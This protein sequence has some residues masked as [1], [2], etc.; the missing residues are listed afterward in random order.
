MDAWGNLVD[1]LSEDQFDDC[2]KKLLDM[3]SSWIM[4]HFVEHY[5]GKNPSRCRC[6][7]RTTHGLSYA[8]ELSRY[9]VG[10]IP[11]ETIH[12]FWQRLSFSNQGLFEPEV[13]ITEE[14]K[15]ISKWFQELD[16]C[17]KVTLKSKL[18][19][20]AY[21]DLKFMCHPLEKVNTKGAQKKPMTKHQRSTRHNPSYWEYVDALHSMQ[22]SISSVKHSASSSGQAIPRRIMLMLDQFHPCIHDSIEN[23]VDVK[24]DTNYGYRA[25]VALLELVKWSDEYINLLGGIDRYEE[26]KQFLLVDGLSMWMNITD[27]G[28][29]IA[30]RYNVILASLSLQQRM[31]SFPLRSQPPI[32]SFVHRVICI[33]HVYDNYFVQ[34]FLRDCCPLPPLALLWSL[35]SSCKAVTNSIY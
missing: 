9:V 10:T 24:A 35:S 7:M 32:D 27:M 8:Y 31:T 11:L 16:V 14:M 33:G 20:I 19:K 3:V 13:N 26:L 25:I 30:S 28:Y 23:I 22:N 34:I 21:L 4:S 17:S 6:V 2:L 1:C 29:V 12:M 5:A 15:I 18:Q